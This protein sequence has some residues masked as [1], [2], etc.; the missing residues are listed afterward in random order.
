MAHPQR[1]RDIWRIVRRDARQHPSPNGGIVEAAFAAALGVTLGGTNRYGDTI[2][3]RGTLGDGRRP[4]ADDVAAAVR[5]RRQVATITAVGL[6]LGS[7]AASASRRY[8]RRNK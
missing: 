5:L 8:L 7:L 2:E 4:T 1:A 6:V 3:H